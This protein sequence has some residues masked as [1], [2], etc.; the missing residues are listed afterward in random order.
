MINYEV[1]KIIHISAI[2][3]TL[4][5]GGIALIGKVNAKWI[6]ILGGV[7]SLFIFISG[8]GLMARIGVSHGE[9]WPLWIKAKVGLWVALAALGPIF[10]KRLQNNRP[11]ASL[12][13]LALAILAA[14][15]AIF[16]FGL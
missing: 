1:Y 8:M 15:F 16:K 7:A 10:D 5:C 12:F 9:G 6:K 11:I 4:Y 13:L 3:F 14:S 2:F